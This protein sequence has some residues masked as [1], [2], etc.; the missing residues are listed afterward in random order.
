MGRIA[1][2]FIFLAIIHFDQALAKSDNGATK[3]LTIAADTWCPYNCDPSSDDKGF[4]VEIVRDA[5]AAND[6]QMNYQTMPWTDALMATISGQVDGVIGAAPS[7]AKGLILAGEPVGQN[8]TC[9]YTRADDPY[10]FQSG[11][12]LRG[13]RI[14]AATGY[15]YGG[16][17]DQYIDA[18]RADYNLVQLTGGS[19]PLLENYRKLTDRRVDTLVENYLVMEFSIKKYRFKSVRVAGCDEPG[20]LH[21]AFS[22]RRPDAGRLAEFINGGIRD[23][24]RSGSLQEIL[25]RYKVSDWKK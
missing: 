19:K 2:L 21:V 11:S 14:G 4:M 25:S 13:R 5:L 22:P 10:R 23:L 18:N 7:E 1:F 12:S 20:F 16:V 24:R 6:Y 9:L 3:T 15:L 17:I 8:M